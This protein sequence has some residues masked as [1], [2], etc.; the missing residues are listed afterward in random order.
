VYGLEYIPA[1]KYVYVGKTARGTNSSGEVI[2]GSEHRNLASGSRRVVIAFAQP[3]LQP[4]VDYFRFEELWNGECSVEESHAI[5]QHFMDI[6]NTRISPRPTNGV[7][8]DIDIFNGE[9]PLQLNVLRSCTDPSAVALAGKRVARE[10]SVV[11]SRCI[12]QMTATKHILA[13]MLLVAVEVAARTAPALTRRMAEFVATFG[14][15]D[16]IGVTVIHQHLN[17]IY[18]AW[19]PDDGREVR[20]VLR[21][22]IGW[23]NIDRR[24]AGYACSARVVGS[25]VDNIVAAF[26][27]K[28][29]HISNK[30]NDDGERDVLKKYLVKVL[31]ER[32][33]C[34]GKNLNLSAIARRMEQITPAWIWKGVAGKTSGVFVTKTLDDI[35]SNDL[36]LRLAPRVV[37]RTFVAGSGT[38]QKHFPNTTLPALDMDEGAS[39]S[40]SVPERP[41]KQL[42]LFGDPPSPKRV[43]ASHT[44]ASGVSSDD[45]D[46]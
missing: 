2:R 22:M 41:S 40:S 19:V 14:D 42:T 17:D 20:D 30:S 3:H 32:V 4:V 28:Y 44:Y 29:A 27:R 18:D 39:T 9:P 5:E 16:K 43:R 15:D 36:G 38:G 46:D 6:H 33:P 11:D 34:Q 1:R 37:G 8:K 21:S 12:V 45:D 10:R 26:G 35:I 7:T 23:Y 25:Q 31:N 13:D 24:G